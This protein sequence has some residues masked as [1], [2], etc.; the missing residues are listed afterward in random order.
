MLAQRI[1]SVE[2]SPF[3]SIMDLAAKRSDCLYL[4]LGEPDFDT[5]S[6]IV[7]TGQKALAGGATHYTPDRGIPELRRLLAQK[8]QNESHAEYSFEDEILIT[9]GGQA[10]L[11]TAIMGTVNP[12]DEVVL[13][14]PYYPPYLANV[15][16][17]G[18]VPVVVP[19]KSEE[20]F[21]PNPKIIE[22]HI[23]K[24][25]KAL[26][27]HSPNNPTGSV[28]GKEVL[29]QLVDLAEERNFFIISDEV[30]EKYIYGD[31]VHWSLVS[32]PNAKE[33]VILVNSFSKTYAMT[34]WRIG[35]IAAPRQTL[36]QFLKYHHTVNICANAAA[37][38]ACVAAL[39]GPQDC[40]QE[41]IKEYDLR[42]QFL[43]EGLNSIPGMRCIPPQGAFYLFTDIRE[44]KM[45][46]LE[47]TKYLVEEVGVVTTNG[48]GFGTEGFVRLSYST[49][50][51][52]IDEAIK[53]IQ[54]AVDRLRKAQP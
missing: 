21:T 28:Y 5:P 39:E 32:F 27:L 53:R 14:S 12:G 1:L 33:R 9:A 26:V 7:E 2:R 25:T 16:L 38:E 46:S 18:G 34:G 48:S 3:Y 36:L 23:T 44:L 22:R 45:A 19:M 8:I 29:S 17:A 51:E 54:K 10:A 24:R 11:H 49:K 20:D 15:L 47:F 52:Q 35:Y 30:Y 42:R 6:H 40:I 43:L 41:M 4:H 31:Q 37:Q 13:L 50:I